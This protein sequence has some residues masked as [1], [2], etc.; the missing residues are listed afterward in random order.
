MRNITLIND[1]S[2]LS[3]KLH[4]ATPLFIAPNKIT[5]NNLKGTGVTI[6][7]DAFQS[8]SIFKT[9]V[10]KNFTQQ[11]VIN[12]MSTVISSESEK[13]NTISN[14]NK[15]IG[16]YSDFSGNL[17]VDI[18]NE[19]SVSHTSLAVFKQTTYLLGSYTFDY[20]GL[21]LSDIIKRI[22]DPTTEENKD[23]EKYKHRI[24][25]FLSEF[26]YYYISSYE[27]YASVMGSWTIMTDSIESKN[28]LSVELGAQVSGSNFKFEDVNKFIQEST[29]K[30]KDTTTKFQSLGIGIKENIQTIEQLD[31]VYGDFNSYVNEDSAAISKVFIVPWTTLPQIADYLLLIDDQELHNE[32]KSLLD[33]GDLTQDIWDDSFSM[34]GR[35]RSTKELI[36][37]SI[38]DP[39]NNLFWGF[40]VNYDDLPIQQIKD[41]SNEI[42][43]FIDKFNKFEAGTF[44]QQFIDF[45]NNDMPE[46]NQLY[47]D[48]ISYTR[49]PIFRGYVESGFYTGKLPS[50][51]EI[52]Q[53]T[54]IDL[55]VDPSALTVNQ[56]ILLTPQQQRYLAAAFTNVWHQGY[57]AFRKIPI[58]SKTTCPFVIH[59]ECWTAWTL[60]NDWE[61]SMQEAIYDPKQNCI[62]AFASRQGQFG[63]FECFDVVH[64]KLDKQ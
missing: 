6:K 26:G 24:Q 63:G 36:S 38:E 44:V 10:P 54:K 58:S 11:P 37:K 29:S 45:K 49:P 52:Y 19:M 18:V 33:G 48:F 3:P 34:L 8:G 41:F 42:D 53:G 60:H 56:D 22:L 55:T 16:H 64:L 35:L 12:A 59:I 13:Q 15:F 39:Y 32:I 17:S 1:P 4:G 30:Q 23:K 40:L 43:K 57:V 20:E 7:G 31:N 14:M 51:F 28:Q 9:T 21:E 25:N 47:A 46:W 27:L 61:K 5:S 50:P 62:E 2:M